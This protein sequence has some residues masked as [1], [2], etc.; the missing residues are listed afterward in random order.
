MENRKFI[1]GKEAAVLV[2]LVLALAVWLVW[3]RLG[4]NW[5][6]V[7]RGGEV[8]GRYALNTPDRIPIQ[9][10]NGFSLTLVIDEGWQARVE[11]STCPDLICQHHAP[12]FKEGESIICLPGRVT[13]TVEGVEYYGYD[14]LSG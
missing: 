8:L 5:V 12:I 9:G 1:S 10:D 6:I 2:V 11:D 7:T 13:I 3:P 4:G 14:A